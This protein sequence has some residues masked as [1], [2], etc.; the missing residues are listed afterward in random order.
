MQWD[1]FPDI[2]EA[3]K[4]SQKEKKSLFREILNVLFVLVGVMLFLVC[5]TTMVF[6]G[7]DPLDAGIFLSSMFA[8]GVLTA[9]ASSDKN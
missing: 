6:R 1:N 7:F 5:F 9:A 8:L 2:P 3:P 4:A